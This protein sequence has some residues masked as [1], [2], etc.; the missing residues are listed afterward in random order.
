MKIHGGRNHAEAGALKYILGAVHV[1]RM[2]YQD[3]VAYFFRLEH[4]AGEFGIFIGRAA[5]IFHPADL[6]LVILFDDALDDLS[7]G[8]AITKYLAAGREDR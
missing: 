6:P 3:D 7:F 8:V 1:Q 5:L 4:N 2:G